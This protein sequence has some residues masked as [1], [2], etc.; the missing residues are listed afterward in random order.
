MPESRMDAVTARASQEM[1]FVAA[2]LDLTAG[3]VQP[4]RIIASSLRSSTSRA[5]TEDIELIDIGSTATLSAGTGLIVL[6]AALCQETVRL[7]E[8]NAFEEAAKTYQPNF[9]ATVFFGS[10]AFLTSVVELPYTA[11]EEDV[12]LRVT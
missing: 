8:I 7:D 10:A 1:L 12:V 2:F 9:V 3:F 6:T 4:P 11:K 5:R